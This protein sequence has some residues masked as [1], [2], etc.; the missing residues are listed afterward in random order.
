MLLSAVF[1]SAVFALSPQG[2][3]TPQ[4][5]TV[6]P[7]AE[8]KTL[9]DR[10]AELVMARLGH[11]DAGAKE[12]D[13]ASKRVSTART[14]LQKALDTAAKKGDW[15]KSMADATAV[16]ANC[17]LYES[18]QP[19]S[20][21]KMEPKGDKPFWLSVPKSYK[22]DKPCRTVLVL[23]GQDDNNNWVDGQRYFEATWDKSASLA[24]VLFHVLSVGKDIDLSSVPNFAKS[25]A[26][27]Q[28]TLRNA[29]LLG[30][31]LG[32]TIHDYN[33]D[34]SR[35]VLDVG[36]GASPY[37]LRAMTYFP[38]RFAG[39]ILRYPDADAVADLRLGSLNGKPV[40]LLSS[41]ATAA[42]C[43]KLKERIDAQAK[44]SCTVI[45]TTDA[46]PFKA[47]TPDIEK[48]LAGVKRDLMRTHIVLEPNHDQWH[49]GYWVWIGRM[50]NLQ[51]APKDK[52]PRI[53]AD[54]DRANNRIT[55]KAVGIEDFTLLL[56]DALV[57][58]DKEFTVIVNGKAMTQKVARSVNYVVGLLEQKQDGDW[59]FAGE[60][61]GRVPK[62]EEKPAESGG[63][64]SK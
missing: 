11:E 44:D 64:N 56:N 22:A 40:L 27:E 63:G 50:E 8:Q 38:T 19:L 3:G 57:D 59:V 45:E 41:P 1:T 14:A 58:L 20:L 32:S 23:P 10:V 48:W 52:L 61:K 36:K 31:I 4:S 7:P 51:T 28:E 6:L 17:I 21:R 18:K 13:K 30:S 49:S 53:E 5:Q 35:L 15:L 43:A 2:G 29:E 62:T 39:L 47:A 37:A 33:I 55:V 54:A 9:H 60:F 16:F 12:I 25:G 42:A 24:D 46:Y 26:Q 34:R